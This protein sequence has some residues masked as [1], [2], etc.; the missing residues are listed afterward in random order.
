MRVG[1]EERAAAGEFDVVGVSCDG[2]KVEGH[3]CLR[4]AERL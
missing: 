1:F 4:D 3:I 2:E